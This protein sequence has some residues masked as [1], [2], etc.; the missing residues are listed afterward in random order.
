MCFSVSLF[1]K[2]F[3]IAIYRA[4]TYL[5]IINIIDLMEVHERM[6]YQSTDRL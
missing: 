1:S 2:Q 3:S 4:V 6:L 5:G